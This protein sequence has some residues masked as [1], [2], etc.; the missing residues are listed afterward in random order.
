[1]IN[2]PMGRTGL[3]VSPLGMGV[4]PISRLPWNESIDVIRGVADHVVAIS[5]KRP[6]CIPFNFHPKFLLS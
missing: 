3:Q 1:M 6:D 2:V 4:I 5:F